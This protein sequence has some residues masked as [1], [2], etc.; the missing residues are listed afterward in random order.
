MG[1]SKELF[2][3]IR[4]KTSNLRQRERTI[5]IEEESL[6]DIRKQFEE[7]YIFPEKDIISENLKVVKKKDYKK[8]LDEKVVNMFIKQYGRSLTLLVKLGKYYKHGLT[9]EYVR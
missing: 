6:T 3:E 7:N 2:E 9:S 8:E 5:E 4:L 1:H